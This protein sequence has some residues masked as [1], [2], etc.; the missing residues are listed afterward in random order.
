MLDI[1]CNGERFKGFNSSWRHI[2]HIRRI[3]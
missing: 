3:S 2:R 1:E